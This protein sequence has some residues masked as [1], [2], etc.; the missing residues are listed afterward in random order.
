MEEKEI[1]KAKF[2]KTI[3]FYAFFAIGVCF[4]LIALTR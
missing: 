3:I 2:K 4:I 1:I